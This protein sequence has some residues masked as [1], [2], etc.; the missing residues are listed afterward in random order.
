MKYL[1]LLIAICVVHLLPAATIAQTKTKTNERGYFGPVASVRTETVNYSIDGGKRQPG[2]RRLDSIEIF[3]RA[4]RLIEEKY[5]T[6]EGTI[7]WEYKHRY[8][9]RGRRA[10]SWGTHSR[11]TYLSD[12]I[13]YSYDSAGNII[14]ENGFDSAGKLVNK[15][16]Y[17]YD[18]KHRKIRWTS[19]SD[20]PPQN[21]K[22]H[23]WTFDYYD[24]NL[25]MEERAF[26][27][28]G[29]GFRPTDSLGAPHRKFFMYNS[30]N[31]PAFVLL[32]NV[33]GGFSGLE[34]TTYDR[35]GNEL[36]EVRYQPNGA[37]KDK[38]KYS[39]LFDNFRNW[40]V[41]KTYEWDLATS[42]YRLS[43][44]SYQIIEY[45]K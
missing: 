4:G 6:G 35:R 2:K 15:S 14:A 11:F 13:T 5:F 28:E 20:Y 3:D 9:S 8:D 25:V 30:Q 26:R 23:Q 7:L 17:A 29:G 38:T 33:N 12:R 37:M 16:E 36:E 34:S 24:N 32:Y 1:R 22:P 21:A 27:D 45:R 43:E 40:V 18:E 19:L 41:Q 10:E 44:I 31:K 39:Y 42:R